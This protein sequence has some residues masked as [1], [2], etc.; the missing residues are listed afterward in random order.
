MT[1]LVSR[2]VRYRTLRLV[3][4]MWIV[5]TLIGAALGAALIVMLNLG[6]LDESQMGGEILDSLP[7]LGF[8]LVALLF[9]PILET[10][11]FQL[12]LLLLAKKLT[13]WLARSDSWLPAFLI[14]S[15]AFAGLH[16][17]NAV[18]TW[19]IYG[20]LHAVARIPGGVALTLL[21]IVERVR[22]GGYPVLSVILLHSM[23]NT[24]PVF[25][26]AVSE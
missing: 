21:A 2:L 26:F 17:T 3:V 16:A 6:I 7:P 24:V 19:S 20:L 14:T 22:E 18:D 1:A 5:T 13:E 25:L 10:W 23:Y 4:V 8:L 15:L 11:V 12:A 9:A